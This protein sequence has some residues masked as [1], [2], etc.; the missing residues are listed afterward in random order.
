MCLMERI[1]FVRFCFYVG[2]GKRR[3]RIWDDMT[4]SPYLLYLK[5]FFVVLVCRKKQQQVG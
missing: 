4:R 3:T 5:H 2:G 1:E